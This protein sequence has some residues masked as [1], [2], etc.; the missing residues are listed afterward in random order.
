M[1]LGVVDML[2]ND[3]RAYAPAQ[4]SAITALGFTGFGCHLDGTLAFAITAADCAAFTALY[5]AVGLDLAQFSL[6]YGECLF[7]ADQSIR[8]QVMRKIT[9]GIA[10]ADQLGAHAL[11]IR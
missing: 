9:R 10:L 7:S 3:F 11:L 6:T 4:L 2:P 1:R 8:E 5:T